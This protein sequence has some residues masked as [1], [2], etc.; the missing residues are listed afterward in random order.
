[1]PA[2]RPT[3]SHCCPSSQVTELGPCPG[4]LGR[5]KESHSEAMPSEF[6]V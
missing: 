5:G 2:N 1:M 4:H 6:A 3:F